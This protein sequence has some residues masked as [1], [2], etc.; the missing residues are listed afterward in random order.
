MLSDIHDTENRRSYS[1]TGA[2]R[3]PVSWFAVQVRTRQ[4]LGISEHLSS[5]GYEWF[6]PL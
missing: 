3:K 1:E 2:N 4:E 5:N 6:L